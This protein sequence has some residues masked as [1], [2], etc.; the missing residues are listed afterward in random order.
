MDYAVSEGKCALLDAEVSGGDLEFRCLIW[1]MVATAVHVQLVW[2]GFV[3]SQ[4]IHQC[5]TMSCV[6]VCVVVVVGG[7]S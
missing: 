2:S 3:N 5:A 4:M 6:C 7:G 1:P